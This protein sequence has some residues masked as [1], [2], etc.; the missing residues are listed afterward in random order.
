MKWWAFAIAA[1]V[2]F[3]LLPSPGTELGQLH[4]VS[5]LLVQNEDNMVRL[6]TDTQETGAGENL[7]AAIRNLE[8]TTTGH[9]FLETVENLVIEE[10]AQY[11]LPELRRQ[12]RPDV[13]VC[14]P[15]GTLDM[16]EM[17]AYL[18]S[19]SPALRLENALPGKKLPALR[20]VEGRYLLED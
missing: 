1:F 20:V 16:E 2:L 3:S 15:E 5:L 13:R 14:C 12:L 18:N 9:L 4:P 8:E 10:D 7:A 19:H 17:S 11:L 6:T